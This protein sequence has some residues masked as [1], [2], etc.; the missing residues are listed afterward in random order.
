MQ[1]YR[2]Y[3]EPVGAEPLPES[4]PSF[5]QI[6]AMRA[7]VLVRLEAPYA[8][9]SVLTPYGRRMQKQATARNFL[10]QQDGSWKSVEIQGHPTFQ[11]WCA[12]WKIYKTVL[13]MLSARRTRRWVD[14]RFQS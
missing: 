8:D 3:R 13:L 9:F 12:C 2:N 7:K 11:A 5:E 10:L 4:D 14:L 1:A 6:A